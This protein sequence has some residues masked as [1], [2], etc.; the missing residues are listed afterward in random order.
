MG[1]KLNS[2]PDAV[3]KRLTSLRTQFCSILE[4][5]TQ[6]QWRCH[7]FH[8]SVVNGQVGL[9]KTEP[10]ETRLNFLSFFEC[11]CIQMIFSV[12]KRG[13]EMP[14]FVHPFRAQNFLY[15]Q[16]TDYKLNPL[17]YNIQLLLIQYERNFT[18]QRSTD[19]AA[20]IGLQC[21]CTS[22]NLTAQL[23]INGAKSQ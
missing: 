16:F 19:T 11:T 17:S 23:A 7:E 2:S 10:Y 8:P 22:T 5:T 3:W 14:H 6:W 9:P 21:D 1:S 18:C 20:Y 4:T 12:F 15:F 13:G